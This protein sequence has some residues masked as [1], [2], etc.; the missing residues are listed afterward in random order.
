[1]SSIRY[2]KAF[3]VNPSTPQRGTLLA[4]LAT[5]AMT[6]AAFVY[7]TVSDHDTQ[8]GTLLGAGMAVV[9]ALLGVGHLS[10]VANDTQA[11]L[12]DVKATTDKLA[13]GELEA[14]IRTVVQSE[15]DAWSRRMTNWQPRASSAPQ[16][17]PI[18][19]TD[20][21]VGVTRGPQT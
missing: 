19:L 5:L 8:A 17:P 15:L 2:G 3:P 10:G 12:D 21:P 20:A 14:K 4:G 11:K 1:M 6:M 9:V 7:L 18:N 13:N 16:A